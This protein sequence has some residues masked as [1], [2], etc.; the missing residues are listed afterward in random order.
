M[1]DFHYLTPAW[2]PSSRTPE[3]PSSQAH[4]TPARSKEPE[5]L[6]PLLDQRL[7]DIKIKILVT[8]GQHQG[9]EMV[10][11]VVEVDGALSIRFTHYKTSGFLSPDQIAPKRPNPTRDNGLLVVI[12]GDHLGQY[13]RRI[14]H[15]YVDGQ[16]IIIL[17]VVN[18]TEDGHETLSGDQLELSPDVLCVAHETKEEKA[19]N[20]GLMTDLRKN[21]SK[22]RAK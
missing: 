4:N 18:R 5:T 3:M 22:I 15:R 20:N 9:K 16:P 8:S 21:A 7:L 1:P 11:S 12:E 17:A 13:V 10:V 2:N 14:H 19:Q 6:H